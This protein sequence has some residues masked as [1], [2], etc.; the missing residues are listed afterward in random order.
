MDYKD[1]EDYEVIR[2]NEKIGIDLVAVVHE[3]KEIGQ[4]AP[5]CLC[6]ES[7][8]LKKIIVLNEIGKAS[9]YNRADFDKMAI[10]LN[11]ALKGPYV[12]QKYNGNDYLLV[13]DTGSYISIDV[14]PTV[15]LPLQK[16]IGYTQYGYSVVVCWG[17][18]Q[19]IAIDMFQNEK[20]QDALE[21]K[22]MLDYLFGLARKPE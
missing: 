3:G 22:Q 6:L 9:G 4:L 17:K 1:Y 5:Y 15:D 21:K 19:Y 13:Q 11:D 12:G 18:P 2:F 10:D 20:F 7:E 16:E 14:V 8:S